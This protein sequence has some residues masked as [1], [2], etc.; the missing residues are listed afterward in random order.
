MTLTNYK[1]NLMGTTS[2]TATFKGM[3]KPD[4]FIVYPL[5]EAATVIQIQSGN[6]F[7]R[8]DLDTGL[9]ILSANSGKRHNGGEWLT[10]CQLKGSAV[11]IALAEEDRQILRSWVKS[12]GAV[13]LV[14]SSFIKTN[15][16]GALAL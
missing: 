2:F 7:G 4:E 12:T 3:R 5:H 9:G 6:R 1:K 14:G 15:N 13:G 11:P 16:S 10:L 8:L